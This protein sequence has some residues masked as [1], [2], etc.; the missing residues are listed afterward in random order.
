MVVSGKLTYC[1]QIATGLYVYGG[2]NSESYL[3]KQGLQFGCV[4]VS[5][6]C[7]EIG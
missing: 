2:P 1:L 4:H 6:L 5:I 7:F 3:I